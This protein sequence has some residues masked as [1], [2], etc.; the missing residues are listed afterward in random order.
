MLREYL[1]E[2]ISEIGANGGFPGQPVGRNTL[3]PGVNRREQIG[4]LGDKAMDTV[5][6]ED[7]LPDHLK[8][9]A[10]DPN[11]CFGPVPPS[12]EPPGVFSDPN[13]RD[14]SPLPTSGIKRGSTRV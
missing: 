2:I 7:E 12:A 9:P 11:D 14:A 5:G 3:A 1:A 4:S 6:D 8:E 10:V 13:V